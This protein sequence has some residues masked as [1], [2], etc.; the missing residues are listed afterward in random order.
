MRS[1]D[2]EWVAQFRLDGFT[3]SRLKPYGTWDE[4]IQKASALWKAFAA[5]AQ[6]IK[7]VRIG[8]RYINRVQLPSGEPF[9]RTFL[10]SFVIGPTLPQA[11]AAYLLRVVI[12]FEERNAIAI[13]TQ[14][15]EENSNECILD[16]DVFSERPHGMEEQE[17]WAEFDGLREVKNR[18]FFG[19]LTN[20]ALERFK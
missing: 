6:P 5:A 2:E 18:L 20:D 9:E 15:L 19:S 10:T 8:L 3:V 17:M 12:P 4:L 1:T 16:L 13:V 7:V 14:S 11:V